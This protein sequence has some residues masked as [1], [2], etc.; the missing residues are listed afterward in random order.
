ML[1]WEWENVVELGEMTVFGFFLLVKS[2]YLLRQLGVNSGDV[3]FYPK[4]SGSK[5]NS[6]PNTFY[7]VPYQRNTTNVVPLFD[8]STVSGLRPSARQVCMVPFLKKGSSQVTLQKESRQRTISYSSV[9][10]EALGCSALHYYLRIGHGLGNGLVRQ[11]LPT[12]NV[13]FV[14]DVHIFSQD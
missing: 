9:Q 10:F 4:T 5:N 2:N 1:S 11:H 12:V 6:E 14:F 3:R 8:T 13:D 7:R